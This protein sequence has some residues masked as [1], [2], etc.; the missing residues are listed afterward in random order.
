MSRL[1]EIDRGE[2]D[3]VETPEE[4]EKATVGGRDSFSVGNSVYQEDNVTVITAPFVAKITE[5]NGDEIKINQSWSDFKSITGYD[6][7]LTKVNQEFTDVEISKNISNKRA[8]NT[9]VHF[10]DDNIK[11]TTNA[12]IDTNTVTEYPNSTIFKLYEPLP[13]DIEEKDKVYVVQEILP[14]LTEEV[15]LIPYQQE[16]ENV[17]VLRPV[18]SSQVDSPI[19]QRRTKLQ[20]YNDLLRFAGS[21]SDI[22]K[23]L[24]R[25][26][27]NQ[28][29]GLRKPAG[30][31]AEQRNKF[32]EAKQLAAQEKKNQAVKAEQQAKKERA[33]A[34]ADLQKS[35]A[36]QKPPTINAPGIDGDTRKLMQAFQRYKDTGSWKR[37]G[38]VRASQGVYIEIENRNY[39][40]GDCNL[41]RISCPTGA[42]NNDNSTSFTIPLIS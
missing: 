30:I 14:Q 1:D 17:T 27:Y 32:R 37:G 5:I 42:L 38:A 9:Y 15:E 10:G 16:D 40:C 26:S 2:M 13:D 25:I 12:V 29:P 35:I 22:D 39:S 33:K 19:S 24:R 21:D 41:C 4:V 23:R 7:E 34:A 20:S 18:E 11:L 8:L 3:R 31:V 28:V 6:E 36:R